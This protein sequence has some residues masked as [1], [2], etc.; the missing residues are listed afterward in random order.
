MSLRLYELC[1]V[2]HA[3]AKA[4]GYIL[5]ETVCLGSPGATVGCKTHIALSAL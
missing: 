4:A 3:H 5:W 1:H 2:T